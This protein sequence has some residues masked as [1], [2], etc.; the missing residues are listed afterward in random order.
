MIGLS[1]MAQLVGWHLQTTLGPVPSEQEDSQLAA[2]CEDRHPPDKAAAVQKKTGSR[3]KD[4]ADAKTHRESERF[5]RRN[6]E[7]GG[8]QEQDG[9]TEM[10]TRKCEAEGPWTQ[11]PS[12]PSTSAAGLHP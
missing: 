8:C 7:G 6:K 1:V 11:R 5:R 9:S 2:R 3:G 12:T 4:D 10:Q